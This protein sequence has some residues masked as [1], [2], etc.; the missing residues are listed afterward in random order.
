MIAFLTGLIAGMIHVWSGPDHL[1][2]LAPISTRMHKKAWVAGLRWG[3]G[4]SAGVG[5]IGALA[6]LFREMIPVELLAGWG[7]RLVGI[8][9]I[10]IGIWGFR[11]AFVVHLHTHSHEHEGKP[12][13]HLHFHARPHDHDK[14]AT[15]VHMHAA[16]GIGILHGL[17]GSSHFLGVLPALAFPTLAQSVLYIIAFA[18]GTILSM[19]IFTM[20]VGYM[21]ARFTGQKM[22]NWLMAGFSLIAFAVGFFW[23]MK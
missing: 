14:P 10:G 11:K 7:E 4:H 1:S 8:L 18:A 19:I 17:A 20:I 12:H 21:G 15:H 13:I 16:L 23:L 22:Y 5:I 9:L 6:L 2:A 3:I